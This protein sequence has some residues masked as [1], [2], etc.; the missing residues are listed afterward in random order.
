MASDS[1]SS[2]QE[3]LDKICTASNLPRVVPHEVY[4]DHRSMLQHNILRLLDGV[5]DDLD[6]TNLNYTRNVLTNLVY[7]STA[8]PKEGPSDYHIFLYTLF[9]YTVENCNTFRRY[10]FVILSW[11]HRDEVFSEET[12]RA[13]RL[14]EVKYIGGVGSGHGSLSEKSV[15]AFASIIGDIFVDSIS[16]PGEVK[17]RIELC[18]IGILSKWSSSNQP[19]WPQQANVLDAFFGGCLPQLQT[20]LPVPLGDSLRNRVYCSE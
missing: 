9:V 11:F 18:V 10:L 3:N 13:I 15:S 16:W 5:A 6:Q 1:H 12:S 8:L 14:L 2:T 17:D 20:N 7:N 4:E 19:H